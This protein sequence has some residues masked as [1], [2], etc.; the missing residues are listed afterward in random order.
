MNTEQNSIFFIS[1]FF[2]GYNSSCLMGMLGNL[3]SGSREKPVACSIMTSSCITTFAISKIYNITLWGIKAYVFVLLAENILTAHRMHIT[4]AERIY[5]PLQPPMFLVYI[6]CYLSCSLGPM[7]RHECFMI[8]W[9]HSIC[10]MFPWLYC[11]CHW[12]CDYVPGVFL[13]LFCG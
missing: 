7:S 2:G 11:T 13:L 5:Y 10:L 4:L 9:S 3:V 1:N 12:S 6:L 8:L